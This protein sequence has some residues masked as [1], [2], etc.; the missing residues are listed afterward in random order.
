MKG[1]LF[2][3]LLAC[4]CL[5][6]AGERLTKME[7]T[8]SYEQVALQQASSTAKVTAEILAALEVKFVDEDGEE[9]ISYLDNAYSEYLN[10]PK[11]LEGILQ[12]YAHA[13]NE[14]WMGEESKPS[15]DNIFPVIKDQFYIDQVSEIVKKNGSSEFPFYYEKL[16]EVLYVLFAL[17]S[18][19]SLKFLRGTAIDELKIDRND[20]LEISKANLKAALP[21]IKI[22]GEP[23]TLSMLIAGGNYEASLLLFDYIWTKERFPVKGDIVI[24]V[25]S[26]DSVFITGS[27]DKMA[28]K[29]IDS[30]IHDENTSWS[31]IVS[32]VGFIRIDGQWQVYKP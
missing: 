6:S 18:E 13:T 23:S 25:P 10:T 11:D 28:L 12:R 24:Y 20:L 1:L 21:Y 5:T 7:F 15:V 16:N 2:V 17:G 4:S 19:N 31:H 29:K 9:R 30:I 3:F 14:I 22:A 8:Q 32:K 26:R 27:E